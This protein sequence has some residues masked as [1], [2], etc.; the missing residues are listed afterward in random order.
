MLFSKHSLLIYLQR[1]IYYLNGYFNYSPGLKTN[2]HV[3]ILCNCKYT[4]FKSPR[5][6]K[7]K[8]S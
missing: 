8:I 4:L 5:E 6:F 3:Q 7:M 2:A 1:N